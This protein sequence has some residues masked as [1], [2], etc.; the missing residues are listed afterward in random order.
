LYSSSLDKWRTAR[1]RGRLTAEADQK[2]GRK[3]KDPKEVEIER[4]RRENEEL[5]ARLEKAELI[6]DVQKKLSLLLGLRPD[7][8]ESDEDT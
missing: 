5:R 1:A 2:R 4:L 7:E 6:I 3:S 8:T